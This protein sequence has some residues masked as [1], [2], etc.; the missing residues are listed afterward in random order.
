MN[1]IVPHDPPIPVESIALSALLLEV[2]TDDAEDTNG[3]H[4]IPV[5]A[6]I[7]A[8]RARLAETDASNGAAA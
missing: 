1:A 7:L 5:L 3:D 8:R 2:L 4:L 6:S